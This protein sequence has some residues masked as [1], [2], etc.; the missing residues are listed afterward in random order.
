MSPSWL[1][2]YIL[3]FVIAVFVISI[4]IGLQAYFFP[5][6]DSFYNNY[7]IMNHGVWSAVKWQWESLGES[8]K[9]VRFP[10]ADNDPEYLRQNRKETTLTWIGHATFLFQYGGYNILTD[11]HMTK[12]TSPIDWLGPSRK[13]PPGLEIEELP[14]IDMVVLSHNHHDHMDRTTIQRICQRQDYTPHFVVP[15][16]VR[17]W[18]LRRGIDTVTEFDWW[19]QKK[20]A[21]WQVHSVPTQ[22]FSGRGLID[23]N[24]TLWSGWVL[25]L[26]DFT[27][28]FAG[29]TGYSPDFKQIGEE[30]GPMDLSLI[31]IGAYKPRWFMNPIHVD[32]EEAVRIHYDVK[33]RFSVGMHWGT[34][35]LADEDLD[36]PPRLL[37]EITEEEGIEDEFITVRHGQTLDLNF[38][39]KQLPINGQQYK[40][41]AEEVNTKKV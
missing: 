6:S 35:V 3:L 5:S 12:R 37:K 17:D 4:L 25:K 16:G 24:H 40:L 1:I 30:L 28:Y 19:D 26:E 41:K 10:L 15:L 8:I 14:E 21:D 36:E 2:Q 22:H 32:P 31:P 7:P 29:D 39:E 18:F 9:V 27:F 13:T 34:F 33:S 23:R 20:I 38:E 11:P